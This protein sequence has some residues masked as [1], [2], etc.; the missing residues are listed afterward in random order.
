[1][2]LPEPLAGVRV[3]EVTADGGLIVELDEPCSFDTDAEGPSYTV[4]VRVPAGHPAVAAWPEWLWLSVVCDSYVAHVGAGT[5]T[6]VGELV[7]E[8]IGSGPVRQTTVVT[9]VVRRFTR[10]TTAAPA[11]GTV[12]RLLSELRAIYFA[13]G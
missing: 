6:S 12:H 13:S 7:Y 1:M 10:Q 5:S 11:A 2:E 3:L 4:T 8:A 9:G